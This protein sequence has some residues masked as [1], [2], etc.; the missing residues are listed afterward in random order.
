M[1]G[2][3]SSGLMYQSKN[4]LGNVFKVLMCEEQNGGNWITSLKFI[5][6]TAVPVIKLKCSYIP[7]GSENDAPD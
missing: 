1:S 7:T 2:I 4:W 6:N 3:S 5:E